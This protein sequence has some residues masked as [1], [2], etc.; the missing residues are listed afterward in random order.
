MD[1][2][3]ALTL[4]RRL[5]NDDVIGTTWRGNEGA[6]LEDQRRL[7]LDQC[8]RDASLDQVLELVVVDVEVVEQADLTALIRTDDVVVHVDDDRLWLASSR[9]EDINRNNLVNADDGGKLLDRVVD[10]TSKGVLEHQDAGDERLTGV[11]RGRAGAT[12]L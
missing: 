7:E 8:T 4:V 10:A 9:I 3:N 2:R 1:R 11:Q 12:I 5:R 6:L